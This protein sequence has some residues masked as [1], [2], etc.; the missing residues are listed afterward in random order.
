MLHVTEHTN[1]VSGTRFNGLITYWNMNI[2]SMQLITFY[3][4]DM[5][6][7]ILILIQND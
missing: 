6:E 3:S 4:I 2:K 7:K 5:R 1:F